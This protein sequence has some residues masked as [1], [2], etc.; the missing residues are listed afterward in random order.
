MYD[1]TEI[2]RTLSG[3]KK[4]SFIKL[5]FYLLSFFYYLY[6]YD[7][8]VRIM[9]SYWR[10]LCSGWLW[11]SSPKAND[12]I[13]PPEATWTPCFTTRDDTLQRMR[14]ERSTDYNVF[15]VLYILIRFVPFHCL[16]VNFGG[17]DRP[18]NRQTIMA[19]I[20]VIGAVG[21]TWALPRFFNQ[22]SC[23]LNTLVF[24]HG[25]TIFILFLLFP[26]FWTRKVFSKCRLIFLSV[27]WLPFNFQRAFVYIPL[28]CL[29][30]PSVLI[31]Q[32]FQP[33]NLYHSFNPNPCYHDVSF[34]P[35]LR[36]RKHGSLCSSDSW[37]CCARPRLIQHSP[38]QGL[39]RWRGEYFVSLIVYRS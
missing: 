4:E 29:D 17:T 30:E 15:R 6:R 34:Q 20:E 37:W 5:G 12:E 24:D 11:L 19:K 16:V 38:Y 8:E 3:H 2:F 28:V 21:T 25:L 39:F 7:S 22:P 1:A 36:P 10:Y 13:P 27:S 18:G 32:S 35:Y 9:F 23:S 31:S 33:S 14:D 26:S